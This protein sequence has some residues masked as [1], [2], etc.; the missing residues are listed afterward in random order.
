M[1]SLDRQ[2]ASITC[3]QV[4]ANTEK[5]V[6]IYSHGKG[7]VRIQPRGILLLSDQKVDA[8]IDQPYRISYKGEKVCYFYRRTGS[9]KYGE[10]C[11]FHHPN[12]TAARG[13]GTTLPG[14][15]RSSTRAINETAFFRPVIYPPSP[16]MPIIYLPTPFRR[17]IYPPTPSAPENAEW[18]GYQ[19]V[20]PIPPALSM[21]IPATGSSFYAHPRGQVNVDEY[22]ERP[23][24]PDCSSY[25]RTG[26][27]KFRSS[28]RFH[29]P[30][31]LETAVK[32]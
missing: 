18:N 19:G 3:H 10:N 1:I 16:F 5:L 31:K 21:A 25:L 7:K 12:P 11:R 30:G 4:V 28:C 2:N 15:G 24:Q 32:D 14:R 17:I 27:C 20:L 8:D 29:H 9:C 22:P 26:N 6:G 13:L 23:G